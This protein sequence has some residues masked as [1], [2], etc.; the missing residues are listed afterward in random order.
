MSQEI[1][2]GQQNQV[3]K[4]CLMSNENCRLNCRGN[5]A[6]NEKGL[7]QVG[8]LKHCCP[9]VRRCKLMFLN[10]LPMFK[11]F[12]LA[13]TKRGRPCGTKELLMFNY[14]RP[15]HLPQTHVG[16]SYIFYSSNFTSKFKN[17]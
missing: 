1:V 10:Y 6:I 9:N 7:W 14:F 2:H 5:I 15:P 13:E 17:S 12:P 4:N 11:R 8:H 3:F 16:G